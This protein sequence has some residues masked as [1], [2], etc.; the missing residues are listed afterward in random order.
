TQTE[1][2]RH[3]RGNGD[4]GTH[5]PQS[6]RGGRYSLP[7]DGT[8]FS[9][10]SG[11]RQGRQDSGS[12]AQQPGRKGQDD[13]GSARRGP[14]RGRGPESRDWED[15]KRHRRAGLGTPES[16]MTLNP[17]MDENIAWRRKKGGVG[18]AAG[19]DKKLYR[20]LENKF[21]ADLEEAKGL[22]P[23]YNSLTNTVSPFGPLTKPASRKMLFYLIAT[24]NASF[25][26]YDFRT[27]DPCD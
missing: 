19:N 26:D 9:R 1:Q 25:P 17:K 3:A 15:G 23:E 10:S 4:S 18:K 21:Q 22:S 11:G 16:A 24:L 20:Y 8:P 13:G 7:G 27:L 2:R 5:T 12:K 6:G 14:K